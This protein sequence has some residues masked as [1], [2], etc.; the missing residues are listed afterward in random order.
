MLCLYDY[1]GQVHSTV[2][3]R[4]LDGD[5][6]IRSTMNEVANL[7]VDGRQALLEK[8]YTKLASLMNHN[9]DLRR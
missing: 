5:E 2:R 4:W 8:D 6:F 1:I 9:F 3:Q 7:A